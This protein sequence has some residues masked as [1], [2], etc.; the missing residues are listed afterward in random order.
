MATISRVTAIES[1]MATRASPPSRTALRLGAGDA[2]LLVATEAGPWHLRRLVVAINHN[3]LVRP[4]MKTEDVGDLR[5]PPD[6]RPVLRFI[7]R[8]F[9]GEGGCRALNAAAV[10]EM[11]SH[12]QAAAIGTGARRRSTAQRCW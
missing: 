7:E 4:G 9:E 11:M 5:P 8:C 6:A 12:E 2:D 1:G 10:E 3:P